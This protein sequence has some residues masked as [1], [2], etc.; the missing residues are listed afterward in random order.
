MSFPKWIACMAHIKHE[1]REYIKGYID[2]RYDEYIIAY[3]HSEKV[4]EHMHFLLWAEKPDDYHKLAQNVFKQKFTLRGKA[5][6]GKCRQYGKVKEIENI[7]KM[8]SYTVKD[9]NVD[10]KQGENLTPEIIEQAFQLSFKKE[11]N[12]AKIKKALEEYIDNEKSQDFKEDKSGFYE[13]NG[14][15]LNRHGFAKE[16]TRVYFELFERVPTRNMI[17][18]Q[19]MKYDKNGVSWYLETI[20]LGYCSTPMDSLI[21][22]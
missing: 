1:N 5:T 4:G 14:F 6:K 12:L 9:E 8:M 10:I 19:I 17:I 22:L 3:E 15:T 13:P 18:N 20:G 2:N 21:N 16:Y 7:Q 11:D